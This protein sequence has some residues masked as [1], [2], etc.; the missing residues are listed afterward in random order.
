MLW[1][2]LVIAIIVISLCLDSKAG[3]TI[4]AAGVIA[5]GLMLVSWITG[6]SFLVT[7]A[8]VCV[9]GIVVILVGLILMSIIGS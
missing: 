7:L 9:V 6:F 4:L 1:V 3:K 5:V 8:K 2:V